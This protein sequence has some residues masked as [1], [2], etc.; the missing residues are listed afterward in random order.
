MDPH[1]TNEAQNIY[2]VWFKP[3]GGLHSLK[4]TLC[5]ELRLLP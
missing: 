4:M 1:D 5:I 3:I 2:Y